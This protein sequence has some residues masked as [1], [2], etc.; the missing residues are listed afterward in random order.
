MLISGHDSHFYC[1]QTFSS[2]IILSNL[3][4][5]N[6]STTCWKE[7]KG[8]SQPAYLLAKLHKEI[9]KLPFTHPFV[10]LFY[11]SLSIDYLKP[12]HVRIV[13]LPL[14]SV[15]F[16]TILSFYLCACVCV[17]FILLLFYLLLFYCISF[18][19]PIL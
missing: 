8:K 6:H 14:S 10:P 11:S 5:A 3:R 19:I 4:H 17:P 7:E 12:F 2:S 13:H 18:F 9:V 16:F 1:C 15:Q